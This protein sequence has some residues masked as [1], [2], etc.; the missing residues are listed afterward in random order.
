M[1]RKEGVPANHF[2][3]QK[4]NSFMRIS[5]THHADDQAFYA[6]IDD[7]ETDAELAYSLPGNRVMDFTHTYVPEDLRGQGVADHI[8]KHGLDYARDKGFKI[9]AT[10]AAVALY[11]RRHPEYKESAAQ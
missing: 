2:V 4:S 11:L 10:C 6:K 1:N 3:Q 5:V 7:Q 8:I 9:K